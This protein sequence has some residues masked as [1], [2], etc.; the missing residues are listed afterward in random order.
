MRARQE[1]TACSYASCSM[2]ARARVR[3]C[4]CV[5]GVKCTSARSSS[6]RISS[7]CRSGRCT[8]GGNGPG[9]AVPRIR[10]NRGGC[11]GDR[12]RELPPPRLPPS[13]SPPPPRSPMPCSRRSID[14]KSRRRHRR[15]RPKES[16]YDTCV[17]KSIT[18]RVVTIV[19]VS[20]EK[21]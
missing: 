1:N 9:A 19:H 8:L 3:V 18:I 4:V 2:G 21:K 5:G 20:N 17:C 13:P 6:R 12:S 7:E 14:G 16:T 15:S 11:G 10:P